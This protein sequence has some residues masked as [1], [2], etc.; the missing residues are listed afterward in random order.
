VFAVLAYGIVS[1][2]GSL[3]LALWWSRQQAQPAQA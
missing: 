3:G 2:L 1:V